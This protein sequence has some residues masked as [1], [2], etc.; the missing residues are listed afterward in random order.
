VAGVRIAR[1]AAALVAL[2]I[3]GAALG[4]CA[5]AIRYADE[6]SN[7]D[8]GRTAFVTAPATVGSFAGLVV[9]VVA[10]IPLLVVTGPVYL[11]R[12][13]GDGPPPDVLSTLFF[14]T[15]VIWQGGKLLAAPFDA[16]EYG[17]YR[18]WLPDHG[19]SPAELEEVERLHDAA[20]LPAY[21][22]RSIF[23]SESW[24]RD[25]AEEQLRA[26]P[27]DRDYLLR[28]LRG[29]D[30]VAVDEAAG[31][32]DAATASSPPGAAASDRR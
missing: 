16:V 11:Y 7:G 21:L 32:P 25:E 29:G 9:G 6:L 27:I 2:M 18:V 31:D 13:T 22:V 14:P 23:P 1:K 20:E 28:S 15:F 26:R 30:D 19:L 10:N 8:G 12:D 3:G 5:S 4:G 17:L 24:A